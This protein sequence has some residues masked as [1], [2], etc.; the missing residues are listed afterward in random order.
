M[1]KKKSGEPVVTPDA[2]LDGV[3]AA[4]LPVADAP[5]PVGGPPPV[6]HVDGVDWTPFVLSKMQPDEVWDGCPTLEGL[7]RVTAEYFGAVVGSDSVVNQSPNANNGNHSCVTHTLTV[8]CYGSDEA[9]YLGPLCG[10]TVSASG[11]ADVFL[12]S[13]GDNLYAWQYSSATCESRAESRAYRRLLRL[14]HIVAREELSDLSK[15]DSGAE[16]YVIPTQVSCLDLICGRIKVDAARYLLGIWKH[17][18]KNAG[19]DLNLVPFSVAAKA[20]AKI[21]PWQQDLTKIPENVRGYK[22]GWSKPLKCMSS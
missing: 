8:E 2:I 20:I 10:R 17:Y 11:V 19:E 3:L 16:G 1:A 6:P 21:V 4:T 12:G 9:P 22:A 15:E 18:D 13:G 7:R 14:R 5:E